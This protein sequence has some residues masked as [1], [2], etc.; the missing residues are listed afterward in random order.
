M[1]ESPYSWTPAEKVIY[2]AWKDHDEAMAAGI[3]GRSKIR[4][5]ADALREAGFLEEGA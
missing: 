5:I 1:A 4:A 3:V 2:Q